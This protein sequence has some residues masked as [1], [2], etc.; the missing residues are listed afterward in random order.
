MNWI[1][2]SILFIST[3]CSASSLKINLSSIHVDCGTSE[4][5]HSKK[6]RFSNLVGEYRSINHLKEVLKILAS[7]GGY[8]EI[9]YILTRNQDQYSLNLK[10]RLKP[11]IKEI[12]VGSVD[13]NID[14]DLSQLLTLREGDFF[15]P[16]KLK[17]DL[18][19]MKLKIDS[20]GF[21]QN[22]YDL[23]VSEIE[24]QAS[25]YLTFKLGKPRIFKRLKSDSKSSFVNEY[26]RRK[27]LTF[28]NRPFDSSKFK[29]YLDDAQKELFN[30]GYYLISL[31]ALPV[32][33]KNRVS[34]QVNVSN[35]TAFNFSFKNLSPENR[36]VMHGQVKDLFRKYKRSLTDTLIKS[37]LEEYYRSKALLNTQILV[38]TFN[39]KNKF[40]EDVISY[41]ISLQENLKTRIKEV[42]FLG[43][44]FFTR[45]KLNSLFQGEA[46]ELSRS[47]F[48]DEEYFNYFSAFLKSKYY[49]NGFVQVKIVGPVIKLDSKKEFVTLDYFIQEGQRTF[50]RDISFQGIPVEVEQGLPNILTNKL[51]QAFSPVGLSE[52]LKKIASELQSKG[53]YYAEVIN[54]NDDSLVTY[55]KNGSD[56][57][58][59][60]IVSAGPLLKLNRIIYLGNIK[61]KKEV[62]SKRILLDR[63]DV[64]T[65]SLTKEFETN[66]SS[67]GLFNSVSVTPMRTNLNSNTLTDLIVK[68][69]ERDYGLVEFAP[70][71]RTDLG[72]KVTA[73]ASY[74]NIGGL[75]RSITLRSQVNQRLNYQTF[76]PRRRKE[77]RQIVEHNEALT[78]TQADIFNTLISSST[79]ASYQIKRFYS[80]DAEILRLNNTFSRDFSSRFS[81]SLRYQYEA[82]TQSDATDNKDNGSFKIGAITPS[83]TYDLRNS[84]VN[85]VKGAF[86]NVSCEFANPYFLSQRESDLTI[87][88]YKLVSR[89]RFYVPFKN[90]T[91]AIS[92]VA[93]LQENLATDTQTINGVTSTEGYIPNIKVFRLTG[94]DIV[95]G[96]NDE[97]INRVPGQARD[98][99]SEVK[100]EQKAY[101]ANFKFEPRYFINDALMAGVFYDAG[102]VFVNQVDMGQ[103]RDSVGITF[104][105]LTPVGTLDF[106][107]GIKLLRERNKNGT[108]EDPGR[109]HVSIG[110]F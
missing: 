86:F 94:M 66:I 37:S 39:Y 75:N 53:Y 99:I 102:R 107:Y 83:L 89:N 79:G 101:L 54:A 5:C 31:E 18:V 108:L 14:V 85:P 71:F 16:Q 2:L 76:D 38:K 52:D 47:G 90:G 11:Q 41:K 58:L 60:Y 55:S 72:A 98:D 27:F 62:L 19:D 9:S 97:E 57:D 91:V 35:D 87:N 63:G 17:Q 34:L 4:N 100:V 22:S 110:F 46:F 13:R 92:M 68:V 70:G 73:T 56:V 49:E 51:G 93:G 65:P 103:L 64:I 10:M 109:F 7:D 104:K 32:V 77:K 25:V 21:P 28:Y 36:I 50:V 3:I 6:N 106:D 8:R 95:R 88:Y 26:L 78:Y 105:I 23:R 20:M 29:L 61:T 96:F 80:F 45:N 67:T 42:N 81:S 15:D 74:T 69:S 1:F 43:N 84:P 24:E 59:N 12:N 44:N 40:N 82:I 30:Y 33:N 48:Y